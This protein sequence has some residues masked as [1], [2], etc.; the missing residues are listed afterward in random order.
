L[1]RSL[2]ALD[3]CLGLEPAAGSTK[4]SGHLGNNPATEAFI[5]EDGAL[6][7]DLSSDDEV[8]G[9]GAESSRGHMVGQ[10]REIIPR[11][12][13]RLYFAI[14]RASEISG[15][16]PCARRIG[17]GYRPL[18]GPY[19]HE[20][21]IPGTFS[22]LLPINGTEAGSAYHEGRLLSIFTAGLHALSLLAKPFRPAYEVATAAAHVAIDHLIAVQAALGLLSHPEAEAAEADAAANADV[23]KV[24]AGAT[25]A[26]LGYVHLIG[27]PLKTLLGL[28]SFIAR[29]RQQV[30]KEGAISQKALDAGLL[31]RAALEEKERQRKQEED[32]RQSEVAASQQGGGSLGA[33]TGDGLTR[34][35]RQQL[36]A[37]QRK[38]EADRKAE[39]QRAAESE[40]EALRQRDREELRRRKRAGKREKE[41]TTV[42]LRAD[43]QEICLQLIDDEDGDPSLLELLAIRAAQNGLL[44]EGGNGIVG[45]GFKATVGSG[46][47]PHGTGSEGVVETSG[48][49]AS[50]N[51]GPSPAGADPT[52]VKQ[53]DD[54]PSQNAPVPGIFAG[55]ATPLLDCCARGLGCVPRAMLHGKTPNFR[56]NPRPGQ[57][58][59]LLLPACTPQEAI[60]LLSL[61][62]P[63]AW[64]TQPRPGPVL[65]SK[66]VPPV[67]P[68]RQNI[69]SHDTSIKAPSKT[70]TVA[71]TPHQ[72]APPGILKGMMPARAV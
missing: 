46:N 33:K 66:P 15:A 16:L 7:A 40:E 65:G 69:G 47:V 25:N 1:R 9:Q 68:T 55:F 51:V 36:L 43:D 19:S 28:G 58:A 2:R 20:Q 29:K 57:E 30:R 52:D 70:D 13:V 34:H 18:L 39:E 49:P 41:I 21:V 59:C 10:P 63:D 22:R 44:K 60:T 45:L 23:P 32:R 5:S 26:S 14:S 35:Q 62:R 42:S 72:A 27:I 38:Q 8:A 11:I 64:L 56:L 50:S 12:P 71:H 4:A 31:A 48:L 54:L 3:P 37:Q 67:L 53:K 6:E 17:E 61:T 24:H